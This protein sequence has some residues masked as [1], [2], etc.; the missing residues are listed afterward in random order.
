MG[1]LVGG[2]RTLTSRRSE[3]AG[4]LDISIRGAEAVPTHHHGGRSDEDPIPRHAAHFCI[5][6]AGEGRAG[7]QGRAV[8]RAADSRITEQVYAHLLTYDADINV[9]KLGSQV[10]AGIDGPHPG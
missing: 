4:T 8:A 3:A 10:S 6:H 9:L 2:Y 5:L 1:S 7:V